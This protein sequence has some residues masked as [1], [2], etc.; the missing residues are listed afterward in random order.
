M[1]VTEE[2][3]RCNLSHEIKLVSGWT[4]HLIKYVAR[5]SFLFAGV[6]VITR[7]M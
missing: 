4:S 5:E 7:D 6:T 3:I 1:W 2:K